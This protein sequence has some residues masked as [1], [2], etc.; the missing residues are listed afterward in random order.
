MSD[1]KGSLVRMARNVVLLHPQA[2]SGVEVATVR[3]TRLHAFVGTAIVWRLFVDGQQAAEVGSGDSCE[4]VV[5]P[6]SRDRAKRAT[7]DAT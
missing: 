5:Y 3:V 7:A 4:F 6:F 1:A 2:M